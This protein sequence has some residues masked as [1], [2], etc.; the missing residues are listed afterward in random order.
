LRQEHVVSVSEEIFP[1]GQK[2]NMPIIGEARF[3]W[4]YLKKLR[5][6]PFSAVS[7]NFKILIFAA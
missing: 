7:G 5:K 3:Y 4:I 2:Q 1:N 6:A